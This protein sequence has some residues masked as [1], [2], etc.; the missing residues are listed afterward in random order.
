MYRYL[1]E[2]KTGRFYSK[3]G[4]WE[5]WRKARLF[6]NMEMLMRTAFQLDGADFEIVVT[7]DYH[8]PCDSDISVPI[9]RSGL[10]HRAA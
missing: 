9:T 10:L 3:E 1:R 8:E 7:F 4:S 2:R 6:E 5:D